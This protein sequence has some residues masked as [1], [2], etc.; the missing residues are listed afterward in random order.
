MNDEAPEANGPEQESSAAIFANWVTVEK[1]KKDEEGNVVKDKDGNTVT[2][3]ETVALNAPAIHRQ[4]AGHTDDRPKRISNALFVEDGTRG[5]LWLNKT[6]DLFGWIQSQYGH[7]DANA[8]Q[9]IDKIGV[10]QSVFDAYLRQNATRYESV[11]SAPHWPLIPDHYYIHPAIPTEGYIGK[12]DALVKWFKPASLEDG[13]LIVAWLLTLFWGGPNGRRPAFLFTG[14]DNDPEMQRGIGKTTLVRTTSMLCGGTFDMRPTDKWD[15]IIKRLLSNTECSTQRIALIDNVKTLRFSWA[16]VEAFITADQ[17]NGR[18]LYVGDGR[19]PNTFTVAITLNGASLSK[20]LAQ[21]CV[22]V[23]LKRPEYSG[24]WESDLTAYIAANRWEIVADIISTLKQPTATLDA[25]SRWG[26]WEREIL[27]RLPNPERL[28]R[29]IQDRRGAVDDDQEEAD[30][31]RETIRQE[32]L[33]RGHGEPDDA[34]VRISATEMAEIVSKALG[35]RISTTA[36]GTKLRTLGGA[37][38]ELRKKTIH[39]YKVWVWAGCSSFEDPDELKP[40]PTY[41][42]NGYAGR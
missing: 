8:V 29:V 11:E 13:Y 1:D 5:P 38:P 37:I 32:L 20:D 41:A 17:I 28:Q 40:R 42:S 33:E 26:L 6:A 3:K 24:N 23:K 30:L 39:G 21:R 19:R 10:T 7:G 18:K 34:T 22:I 2:E 16:D 31:I 14:E 9:W 27:G 12:L 4:L 15:D 36:A 25:F 35:E